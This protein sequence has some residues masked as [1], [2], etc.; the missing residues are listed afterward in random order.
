MGIDVKS[1]HYRLH[2]KGLRYR[3]I[4]IEIDPIYM[5]YA[6]TLK[7]SWDIEIAGLTNDMVTSRIKDKTEHTF[8]GTKKRKVIKFVRHA[9]TPD[10]KS[11]VRVYEKLPK[12]LKKHFTDAVRGGS[13]NEAYNI[14]CSK[15]DRA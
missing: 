15:N 8:H 13:P 2:I 6:D 3:D 10:G 9:S 7:V 4:I 12:T 5:D 1:N 11:I 14:H